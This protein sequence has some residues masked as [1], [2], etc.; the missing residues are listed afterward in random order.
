V[1]DFDALRSAIKWQPHRLI[2]YAFDLAPS[3]RQGS[4][5]VQPQLPAR[6]RHLAGTEYLRHATVRGFTI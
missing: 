6:V 4:G 2:F 1:F 3:R 5:W